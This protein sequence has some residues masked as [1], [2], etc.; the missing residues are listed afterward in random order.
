MTAALLWAIWSDE[1]TLGKRFRTVRKITQQLTQQQQQL[2]RSYQALPEMQPHWTE[3]ALL[4]SQHHFVVTVEKEK[5]FLES[6]G[7]QG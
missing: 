6:T 1:L 4:R 5:I 7:E 2:T 3:D